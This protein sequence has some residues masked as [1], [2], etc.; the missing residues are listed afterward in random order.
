M[1]LAE[2]PLNIVVFQL[3][4]LIKISKTKTENKIILYM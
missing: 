3:L 2:K 4:P 1:L